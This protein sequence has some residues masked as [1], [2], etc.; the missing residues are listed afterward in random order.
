MKKIIVLLLFFTLLFVNGCS[1]DKNDE[2]IEASSTENAPEIIEETETK[3]IQVWPVAPTLEFDDIDNW[4]T[5][6]K[7]GHSSIIGSG[8]SASSIWPLDDYSI[9]YNRND[10]Y[11]SEGKDSSFESI[12][13]EVDSESNT[14]NTQQKNIVLI[15]EKAIFCHYCCSFLFFISLLIRNKYYCT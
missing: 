14:I 1:S 11:N 7:Y 2:P 15:F 6:R 9:S 5:T 13:D 10:F 3:E 12:N 8:E 4:L